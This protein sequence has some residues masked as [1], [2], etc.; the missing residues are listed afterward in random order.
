MPN[1]EQTYFQ[2]RFKQM[3]EFQRFVDAFFL[4]MVGLETYSCKGL[5]AHQ[6]SALGGRDDLGKL[7]RTMMAISL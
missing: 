2:T 6:N 5:N 4:H 3:P 1:F 7:R